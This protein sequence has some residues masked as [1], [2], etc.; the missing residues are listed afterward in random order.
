MSR[1]RIETHSHTN[2]VSPCGYL[3]PLDL[4]QGYSRAGYS[5]LVVTD[6]LVSSLPIF[7][8]I[9]SWPERVGLFFSGFRAVQDAAKGSNLVVYPGFELTFTELPGRDFLVY[10]IDEKRLTEMPDVCAMNPA[11]FK[12]LAAE[13]GALVF[14]AHPFR[15]NQPVGPDLI[16]GL[17]VH[18]GNPRHDSQ[19]DLASAYVERYGLLS[20]SGSDAHRLED[21]GRC[22]ITLPELPASVFDLIRWWREASDEIELLVPSETFR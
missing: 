18:N 15:K 22:G 12:G 21:I 10:G 3:S 6:H 20:C 9:E 8:D 5:G 1:H 14:Q 11:A 4:V 7:L 2:V 16:D 13:V 19:N 17:E